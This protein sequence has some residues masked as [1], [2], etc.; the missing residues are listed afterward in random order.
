MPAHRYTPDEAALARVLDF[1]QADLSTWR[2][3][4]WLNAA[5]D[6]AV[7]RVARPRTGDLTKLRRDLTQAQQAVRELLEG[8]AGM[9]AALEAGQPPK[10]IPVPFNGLMRIAWPADGR[11]PFVREPDLRD[12][13]GSIK[14]RFIELL[15]RVAA[16]RLRRCQE[17]Q[18]WF[19]ALR[20][21]QDYDTPACG[22]RRRVRLFL[23]RQQASARR[24]R[25]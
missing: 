2:E 9:R 3:G 21:T 12:V 19:V 15:T 10:T 18:R 22:N 6:L 20:K 14:S 23:Q 1:A 13:S 25:R 8:V 5:E 4:D 7:S 16:N 24:R 11:G 17:C